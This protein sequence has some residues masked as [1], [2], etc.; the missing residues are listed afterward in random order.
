MPKKI[1]K[2]LF[3]SLVIVLAWLGFLTEGSH[4][5]FADTA[6]LTGNS[7]TTGTAD[8]LIS[9]SQSGSSTVYA[10]E[11]IGFTFNLVPGQQEDK[12]FLLKNA[13]AEGVPFDI[14]LTAIVGDAS[15]GMKEA[16]KLELQPVDADGL[17][18]GEKFSETLA[19]LAGQQKAIGLIIPEGRAQRI[20]IST[21]LASSFYQQAST[22]PYDLTFTGIQHYV[23]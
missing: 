14:Y 16:V 12:Y 3:Y 13:S 2:R 22:I 19:T 6:V 15:Q 4:A 18:V 9:N 23:Q 11:R 7:V 20:K 5:L 10:P 21:S 1:P 17:A 8:L